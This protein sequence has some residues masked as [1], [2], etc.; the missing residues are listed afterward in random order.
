M[1]F[2]QLYFR[3]GATGTGEKLFDST[4]DANDFVLRLQAEERWNASIYRIQEG[5]IS[6]E[7][8]VREEVIEAE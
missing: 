4:E 5:E 8:A 1:K 7:V 3:D 6:W 2:Y